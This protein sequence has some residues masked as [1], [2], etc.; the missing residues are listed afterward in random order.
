VIR[1]TF[2][3]G[4]NAAAQH[5]QAIYP[6]ITSIPGVKVAVPSNPADAKGLL[7]T[8]IRDDD[9]VVFFEH[10]S[11]YGRKGDVPEGEYLVPFGQAAVAREGDD[12]TLVAVGRMV[13]FAAKAAEN[14]AGE[15][16]SAEVID[17]RTTSPLDEETVLDSVEK[18]GRVV[19]IDESP[20]RCSIASD[21]AGFIATH[22]FSSLKAPVEQV[23]S[24]HAPVPFARELERAFTPGPAA[25]EAAARRAVAYR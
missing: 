5:S 17:L 13:L 15:G 24:P 16:I 2:G 19:V 3:A 14:L 4:M 10:K 8:A 23:T 11:L 20:P 18:T 25:I 1:M 9:P 22:G 21:L 7:T 6:M 12:V